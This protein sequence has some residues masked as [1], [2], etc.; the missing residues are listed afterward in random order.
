MGK[1]GR[2]RSQTRTSSKSTWKSRKTTATTFPLP[3]R[4]RQHPDC[5]APTRN[6]RATRSSRH[7]RP[8][9]RAAYRHR[10]PRR[11][12]H[13]RH[14]EICFP[15]E[16]PGIMRHGSGSWTK[17]IS[18]RGCFW[19]SRIIKDRGQFELFLIC[20]LVLLFLLQSHCILYNYCIRSYLE[21]D[22]LFGDSRDRPGLFSIECE[23][24]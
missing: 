19:I 24:N 21:R 4:Q 12:A 22:I 10:D 17:G 11:S 15:G 14:C 13:E 9:P 16:H 23:Y 6:R 20:G 2:Q 8:R 18:S 1:D 5:G 3:L 7:R